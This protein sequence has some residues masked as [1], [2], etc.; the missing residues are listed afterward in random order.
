MVAVEQTWTKVIENEYRTVFARVGGHGVV[1][2]DKIPEIDVVTIE[3]TGYS[4]TVGTSKKYGRYEHC[5][6]FEEALAIAEKKMGQ[7]D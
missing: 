7:F 3:V 5:R 2:I 4:Y 6:T 1:T